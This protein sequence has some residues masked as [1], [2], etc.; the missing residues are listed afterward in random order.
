MKMDV[1]PDLL[2]TPFVTSGYLLLPRPY[3]FL[4]SYMIE[5]YELNYVELTLGFS[6]SQ[7][8]YL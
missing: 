8:R 3:T 4:T 1:T 6:G 7:K 2:P 5:Q